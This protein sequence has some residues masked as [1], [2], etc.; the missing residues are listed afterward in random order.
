[1]ALDI[2]TYRSQKPQPNYDIDR[3]T[4]NTELTVSKW[5]LNEVLQ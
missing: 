5:Y 4:T 2:Q 3:R 1:M